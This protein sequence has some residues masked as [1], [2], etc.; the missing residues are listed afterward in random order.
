L[1]GNTEGTGGNGSAQMRTGI[2]PQHSAALKYR[3]L[4]RE[5][6]RTVFDHSHRAMYQD[7]RRS[8]KVSIQQGGYLIKFKEIPWMIFYTI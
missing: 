7:Y 6:T 1:R 2:N 5:Q 3:R 4:D 8:E